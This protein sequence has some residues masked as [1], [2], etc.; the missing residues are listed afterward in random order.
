MNTAEVAHDE[1]LGRGVFS[2]KNAKRAERSRIPYHVFLEKP[3]CTDISVNR[4]TMAS[5]EAAEVVA[6]AMAVGRGA[7]FY[8]WAV[9]MAGRARE[10]GRRVE[11]APLRGNA[12]HANIVLPQAAVDD[13][14]EQ[15][16]HAQELAD[17]SRWRA[18]GV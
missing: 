4:L 11:S 17:A 8:G 9:V 10:N 12:G 3:G 13:R 14:E 6:E 5:K 7:T 15:K 2:S 18:G 16:R 1:D